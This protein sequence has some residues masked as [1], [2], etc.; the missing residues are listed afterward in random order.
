MNRVA[1]LL[2]GSWLGMQAMGYVVAPVLFSRLERLEAGYIAG[3]VF[4][5][6]AYF[7]LL[8]WA[9]VY[10]VLHREDGYVFYRS[11]NRLIKQGVGVLLV[12]LA[13]NQFLITPV[14]EAHKNQLDYWLLNLIGGSFA[15][16]HGASSIVY[17]L[18]S[19]LGLV[20]LLRLL[21]LKTH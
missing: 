13:I 12:L 10:W 2:A 8:A 21:N 7:G 9:L 15:A 11:S 1:A 5:V 19:V 17:L 16:W 3:V 20:L 6:N 18:S 4:A 14:I